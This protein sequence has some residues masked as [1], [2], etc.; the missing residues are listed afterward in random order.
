MAKVTVT[1]G[2][3]ADCPMVAKGVWKRCHGHKVDDTDQPQFNTT[4]NDF[5]ERIATALEKIAK[6]GIT[7]WKGES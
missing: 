1:H 7:V 3:N 4:T 2:S 5:L 6:D